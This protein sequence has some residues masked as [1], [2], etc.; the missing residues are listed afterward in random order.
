MRVPRVPRLQTCA[1]SA[2]WPRK[3]GLKSGFCF[4]GPAFFVLF[5]Q[6]IL[7]IMVLKP[8][9]L[10]KLKVYFVQNTIRELQLFLE[11]YIN[12]TLYWEFAF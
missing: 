7:T 1:P 3:S 8:E 9:Q 10:I 2:G 11:E 5:F 4:P 12:E 6:P